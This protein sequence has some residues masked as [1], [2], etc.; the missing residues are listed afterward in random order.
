[1]GHGFKSKHPGG[2][3]F[4]LCDGL[5]RFISEAIDLLTYH[6]LG[7]RADEQAAGDC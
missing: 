7:E 6:R 1:V 2:V 5:V 4:V 3:Q